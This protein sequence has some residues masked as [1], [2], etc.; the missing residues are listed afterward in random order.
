MRILVVEDDALVGA[1]VVQLLRE[2]GYAVDL[3]TDAR[4]GLAVFELEPEDL[5]IIDVRLPGMRAGGV[6]LCRHIRAHSAEVPILML[7]AI[8][9]RATL[10]ECLDAGAD[11]YLVKPFHVEEL[12]AR[13]RALMRRA[14]SAVLPRVSVGSLVLD[15]SRRS[16]E[17]HGRIIPLTPKEF[18][19]LEYLMRQ[20]DVIVSSSALIDHAWDRNYEGFSNVV[21]T[22]IRY[23]RRKL[24]LPGETD[25]I[26]THRGAGYSVS[27]D[28]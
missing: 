6:E 15:P 28:L 8:A 16:V 9:A 4:D 27:S 25:P 11:D 10:V 23:L 19:V 14:P 22:N 5:V 7:T 12:L 18:S 20:P 21:P 3:E 24:A 2:A 1:T 13:V 26:V 17:R